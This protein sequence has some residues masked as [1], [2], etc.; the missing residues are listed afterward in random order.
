M[1]SLYSS[2]IL[3]VPF[4]N[5]PWPLRTITQ[6]L[7][8]RNQPFMLLGADFS[9][10]GPNAITPTNLWVS[11]PQL[12]SAEDK[13]ESFFIS[14]RHRQ[15][16]KTHSIANKGSPTFFASLISFWFIREKIL[17]QVKLSKYAITRIIKILKG[18]YPLSPR[19]TNHNSHPAISRWFTSSPSRQTSKSR[20]HLAISTRPQNLLL[21]SKSR[22][23]CSSFLKQ[24]LT[25]GDE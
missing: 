22:N 16:S 10:I 8:K 2:L 14:F 12:P 15:I 5:P 6:I 21:Q 9:Q 24:C 13:D 20:A 7:D 19:I 25:A 11:P 17:S 23:T 18:F 1:P 3:P 4:F